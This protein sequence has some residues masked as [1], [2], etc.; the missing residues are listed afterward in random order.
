MVVAGTVFDG[1]DVALF[2]AI[3]AALVLLVLAV[4]FMLGWIGGRTLGG[5]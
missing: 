4:I 1:G 3:A 5:K 2:I